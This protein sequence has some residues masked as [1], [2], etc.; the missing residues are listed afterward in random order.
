MGVPI[1][2]PDKALWPDA[3]DNKPV[4]KLDLARYLE[5]VGEWMMPHIKG[6]PCSIVRAPDGIGGESFFQRHAMKGTSNLLTLAKVSGD[7]QPYLQI[8]RIEGLAAVAQIAGLELHPWNCAPG[9]PD[10]PGRLV[11]DLDPAPDVKFDKVIEGALEIRDRLKKLGLVSFLQDD[12]RQGP[13]CRHAAVHHREGQA[14]LEGG[15]S[16][17][18]RRLRTDGRRQPGRISGRQWRRRIAA[19]RSSS[20]ICATTACRPPWRRCLRARAKARRFR[21]R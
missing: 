18:A 19:E 16:L 3:G 6:R 2:H 5:A 15:E 8:D 10:V 9:K 4:T 17:R 11:F 1:S 21:C 20:T 14:R 13:A 7:R 12:R